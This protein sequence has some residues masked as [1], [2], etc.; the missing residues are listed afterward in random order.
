MLYVTTRT[1]QDAFT[2]FRALSENRGPE[3][4]FFVPMQFPQFDKQQI[5]ALGHKP[6]TQNVADILNIFFGTHLDAWSLE[7]GIG[8][9][10]VKIEGLNAKVAVAKAWHNPVYRFDRL[11]SGIEKLI[12]KSDQIE[13]V[14]SDWLLLVSRIAVLFGIYGQ[15]LRSGTLTGP[16]KIDIA[17]P[18]KDLS[19]LMAAWYARHMGLPIETIVCCCNE[20]NS[21]WNLLHKGELRTDSLAFQTHTQE[22]DYTVPTDLERLIFATLGFE[23]TKRFYEICRIGGMYELDREKLETLRDGIYVSVVSGKRMASAI[24]NL[25]KTTG[26]VADP[27]TALAHSGLTDYRAVTGANRQGLLI[28]EESP[29]FS[30]QFIARC[31]NMTPEELRLRLE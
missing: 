13:K 20:N 7:F 8:R 15:L 24:P 11:V 5:A 3:G 27:Y 4:G 19:S 29:L 23:E 9:Y 16:Q 10:P 22:C 18:S 14:P 28:A 12:R 31:M 26:F 21:I 2:A 25:Y 30:L 17:V 6:F 1:Q